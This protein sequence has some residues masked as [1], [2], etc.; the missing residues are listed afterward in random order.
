[1]HKVT[2]I[3][4]SYNR[5]QLLGRCLD[6]I[7]NQDYPH[8]EIIVI[9]DGSTD[10]TALFITERYPEVRLIRG[11]R[12]LG[13]AFAK[14]LGIV[15]SSGKYI[16]FL[17]SDSE[18]LF[19][20]TVSRMVSILE[21][22]NAIGMLGGIA[23]TDAQGN[24]SR[25]Y[26][27]AIT[28]DGRSRPVFLNKDD[29]DFSEG[30]LRE[31]DYAATCSCFVRS[32]LLRAVG[33]FDPYYIYMGEDKELGMKIRRA[34]HKV[35]FGY[36]IACAHRY[37]RKVSFDR[38]FMYLKTK[39]RFAV[40]NRGLGYFVIMPFLDMFF[41]FA[42]YP[43]L[44]AAAKIFPGAARKK[45]AAS[46]GNPNLRAPELRWIACSAYY[47]LKAYWLNLVEMPVTLWSRTV[48][49]LSEDAMAAYRSAAR[50]KGI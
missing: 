39:L 5:K 36:N 47:F 44:F 22:D 24:V 18:L 26:G 7:R 25:V 48:D 27:H 32:G 17:D 46:G 37:D 20:E 33:G 38:R 43:L 6:S 9:D 29:P 11:S 1:M 16:Y 49:F 13:P 34:G 8:K 15:N 50:G 19:P 14:N 41:F 35:F 4:P 45:Y 42:W 12:P 3:I 31:C 2:I 21:S 23:E 40:K 30:K 28:H 10:D